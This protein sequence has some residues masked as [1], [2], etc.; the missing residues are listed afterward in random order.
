MSRRSR[1]IRW[2]AVSLTSLL[3]GSALAAP[4]RLPAPVHRTVDAA[5]NG[6]AHFW[7]WVLNQ[8]RAAADD[9]QSAWRACDPT[10]LPPTR[11]PSESAA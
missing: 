7:L 8:P 11:L 10:Q 6:A 4:D 3:L 5:V 2:S 9:P 1:L